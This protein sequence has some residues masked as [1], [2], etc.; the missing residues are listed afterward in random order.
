MKSYCSNILKTLYNTRLNQ[1]LGMSGNFLSLSQT[2]LTPSPFP[3]AHTPY[4]KD[5]E[6]GKIKIV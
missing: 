5:L 2:S 1:K 4:C 3:L 6:P